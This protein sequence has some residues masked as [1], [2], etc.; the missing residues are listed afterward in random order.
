MTG[1][2][3]SK[4]NLPVQNTN[5]A[6]QKQ[7]EAKP[8]V[9]K[10]TAVKVAVGAGLA[11]LASLGIYAA[12]RGKGG[13][14]LSK[15][16]EELTT[17]CDGFKYYF[18]SKQIDSSKVSDKMKEI[19]KLSKKEKAV[20]L[21][22]L[23]TNLNCSKMVNE[24]I[25]GH[26]VLPRGMKELPNDVRQ[27][28]DEKDILKTGELFKKHL[29]EIPNAR[30]SKYRGA[31]VEESITNILGKDSGVKP[32]TY[33]TS[34]ENPVIHI[35]R[36]AGGYKDGIIGKE[37]RYYVDSLL[38]CPDQAAVINTSSKGFSNGFSGKISQMVG[39]DLKFLKEE[40]INPDRKVVRLVIPDKNKEG[41]EIMMTVLSP[42]SEYTP[43]Q[44]DIIKLMDNYDK[45]DQKAIDK[46][47]RVID[48]KEA[49][50]FSGKE[51]A[52]YVSNP[53][54]RYPFMD[55]DVMLSAIQSMA[56]KV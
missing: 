19:S 46:M 49:H 12:T 20:A 29:D 13:A 36:N 17:R 15:Q 54:N 39:Q 25:N 9:S 24:H 31:T 28:Y 7:P 34:K 48:E 42:N 22:E 16:I 18:D 6:P 56:N 43:L 32:H 4:P 51:L 53:D 37:G 45:I 50:Q 8:K 52:T 41:T 40:G 5:I 55:Y 35:Y 14:N 27:A 44:K 38:Y 26:Q 1:I 21:K 23:E 30:P 33:V 47:T 3:P 11:A 10:D 2:E